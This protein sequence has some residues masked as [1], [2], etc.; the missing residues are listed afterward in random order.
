[1][2]R[3]KGWGYWMG[4]GFKGREFHLWRNG[5]KC[6][7]WSQ[8]HASSLGSG[9]MKAWAAFFKCPAGDVAPPGDSQVSAKAKGRRGTQSDPEEGGLCLPGK[10]LR[11]SWFR[12]SSRRVLGV[13]VALAQLRW[14]IREHSGNGRLAS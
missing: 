5:Q 3:D 8:E 14:T 1:M 13:E 11:W 12:E 7:Q 10:E 2:R 9:G 6:A 4:T